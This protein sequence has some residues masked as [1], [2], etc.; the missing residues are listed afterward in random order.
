MASF[1]DVQTH[2]NHHQPI[3][4]AHRGAVF[5]GVE[6]TMYAFEK[7]I[8]QGA[9]SLELDVVRLTTG[10]L[11]VFH[12]GGNHHHPGDVSDLCGLVETHE[13]SDDSSGYNSESSF[14]TA[15]STL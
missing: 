10:E 9:T 13:S 4:Y 12:G 8:E 2:P 14:S 3:I 11:V 5:H 7:A 6:N 1:P 15:A